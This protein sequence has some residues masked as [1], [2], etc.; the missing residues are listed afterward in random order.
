MKVKNFPGRKNQRRIKAAE[1]IALKD[2]SIPYVKAEK[3]ALTKSIISGPAVR[4]TKKN[5]VDKAK[6]RKA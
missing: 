2:S 6:D 4:K 5:R 1:N 3:I